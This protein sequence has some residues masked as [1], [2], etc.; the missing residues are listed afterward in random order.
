MRHQI[1]A[2]LGSILPNSHPCALYKATSS[3]NNPVD[4]DWGQG[5]TEARSLS[6]MEYRVP[7]MALPCSLHLVERK[8]GRVKFGEYVPKNK[9]HPQGAQLGH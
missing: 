6:K 2:L 4:P 3:G 9:G 8:P 7:D 1:L 5:G